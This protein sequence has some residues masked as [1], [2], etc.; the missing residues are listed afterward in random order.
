[1]KKLINLVASIILVTCLASCNSGG[2]GKFVGKWK[3]L[4]NSIL[5]GAGLVVIEREGDGYSLSNDNPH[6]VIASLFYNHADDCLTGDAGG[7]TLIVNYHKDTRHITM[8]PKS[9]G[10]MDQLVE[11]EKAE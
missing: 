1:M 8:G 10:I 3:P 11:L 9:L 7:V 4:K 5:N 2:G 6:K